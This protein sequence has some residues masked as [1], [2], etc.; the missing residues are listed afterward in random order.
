MLYMSNSPCVKSVEDEIN[1]VGKKPPHVFILGAGASKAA[2]PNGDAR[3]KHLPLMDDLVHTAQ[4]KSILLNYGVQYGG[5]NFE[6]LYS[7]LTR[8]KNNDRLVSDIECAIHD[9]FYNMRLP[10]EPTIYDYLILGLR[11]KDLIATF[12]WDPLLIQAYIRNK[13]VFKHPPLL[14]FLH[15]NVAVA[16]CIEHY[17]KGSPGTNCP[18]CK[19][20]LIPSRLLYPVRQKNY[21]NDPFIKTEWETTQSLINNAFM[22]TIFGYG[23]PSTDIEAV[24]LLKQAW[25]SN[26]LSKLVTTEIIDIKDKNELDDKWYNLGFTEHNHYHL[27]NSFYKSWVFKHPRRSCEAMYNQSIEACFISDNPMPRVNSLEE[28]HDWIQPLIDA[29]NKNRC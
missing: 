9:Y 15:G 10:Q 18:K 3:G 22:L 21:N 23:A 6:V 7:N 1:Q 12:N 8:D 28:L 27:Q 25:M 17:A 11:E 4:L 13:Q 16:S 2:L 24:S 20:Q 19:K 29:E 26:K 5:G 14:K